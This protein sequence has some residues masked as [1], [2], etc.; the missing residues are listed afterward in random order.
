MQRAFC[1]KLSP[2]GTG[3][4]HPSLGYAVIS[5]KDKIIFCGG[6]SSDFWQDVY[7]FSICLESW[8]KLRLQSSSTWF[9][10]GHTAVEYE[11]AVY[12]FGG[13]LIS[14]NAAPVKIVSSCYKLDLKSNKWTRFCCSEYARSGHS[15]IVNNGKMIVFGGYDSSLCDQNNV[16]EMDFQSCKWREVECSG[17][18]IPEKRRYH[19]AVVYK[20]SMIVFG[21]AGASVTFSDTYALDLKT[22]EW[23]KIVCSG[24]ILPP[25]LLTHSAFV[26]E[27]TMF[28]FGGICHG[29]YKNCLYALDMNTLVWRK[30]EIVGENLRDSAEYLVSKVGN[31]VAV[32]CGCI[33]RKGLEVYCIHL[34]SKP[35]LI[36]V[37]KY[38]YFIDVEL[39]CS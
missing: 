8:R 37:L 28:I 3:P 19:S 31:K 9:I 10:Y 36:L 20:D 22:F 34:V 38:Q 14:N 23:R 12:V 25:R 17:Y 4:S 5:Y 6:Y 15:A 11:G 21:G 39:E 16:L 30:V 35:N 26:H 13:C 1:S 32:F 24:T 29:F 18:E 27:D 2:Q 33:K 7:E